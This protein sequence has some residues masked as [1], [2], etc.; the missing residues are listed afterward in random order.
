VNFIR[1]AIAAIAI[2]FHV[3][4]NRYESGVRWGTGRSYLPGYVQ[5]ARFDADSA[6]RE[7]IVRKS[8]YFERNSAIV[9]RLSDIFE[10]FTVGPAGLQI[11]PNSSDEEWN[12]RAKLFFSEWEKVCDLT[13]LQSFA[14]LQSLCA[15]GW[16]N[17]GEIF[18]LKTYGES[19]NPQTGKPRLWPRI[20]IVESHRVATPTL[21]SGDP[22]I[23]D[24]IEV[25]DRGRPVAY[26]IRDGLD[27]ENY[28]R[29]EAFRV[30]HIFEPSRPGQYR[31][32]PFGY[33]VINDLHDL[34]DLEILEMAAAKD[35]AEKSTFI[36][37]ASGEISQDQ[38][39]RER[40]G[41]ATQT[42]TGTET[43]A[44]RT[45][46]IKDAI[47]GRVAALRT[48]EKVTQFLSNR[49]TVTQQ[50]YW[51][52]LTS[53][54]CAGYGISKLLVYPWALQGTVTRADLDIMAGFFRARSGVLAT[55]FV[56]VWE[57]VIEWGTKNDIALADPPQDWRTVTVRAPRAV[58]VDVGRNSSAM[59]AEYDAKLRSADSIFAELGL[60]WRQEFRQIAKEESFKLELEKEFKLPA[61]AMSKAVREAIQKTVDQ[62]PTDPAQAAAA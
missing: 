50:W 28:R 36:E 1:R 52:Y 38:M 4:V 37:T 59:I 11:V 34:D 51:D 60:D 17:D 8:R 29:V 33:S 58:N 54:I 9:N 18:I 56:R 49:P 25:D 31:G 23:I 13:S 45:K 43:T 14:T 5:D 26:Y 53:K 15:R 19:L 30:I 47:G 41:Q 27:V 24:G 16:F 61:G 2:G 7:E 21:K 22:K 10:Q 40:F 32:L 35:A 3:L 46:L 39:R 44:T 57:F 20:Q 12:Q 42:S 55:A 6:T 62:Q 48:G